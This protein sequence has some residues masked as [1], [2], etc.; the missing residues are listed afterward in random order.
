MANRDHALYYKR[1]ARDWHEAMPLGNGSMGAMVFGGSQ[2]ETLQLNEDTL[3]SGRPSDEGGYQIK[4][5][6]GEVR[7]LLRQKKYSAADALTDE[8]TGVHDSES[9]QMAGD[10]H[11]NFGK[12]EVKDFERWLD[13]STG[14]CSVGYK[15]DGVST[16][17]ECFISHPHQVLAM[18]MTADKPGVVDFDLS[19]SSPLSGKGS[20]EGDVY[21]FKGQCPY[22]NHSRRPNGEEKITWEQDGQGGIKYVVKIKVIPVGGKMTTGEK[23]ELRVSASDEA[24][25]LMTI[26]TGFRGWDQEPCDDDE[27]LERECDELISKAEGDGWGKI[28]SAHEADFK[29]LYE[30]M[31]LDLKGEDL[32]TTDERLSDS[33][34]ADH[35]RALVNLVFNFGRYLLVSSSRVGSQPTNLQGIWNDKLVA[36]WRSNYTVNINTEMNYWPAETCHL[37]ELTEPL[38]RMIKEL[39]ISGRRPAKKLYDARGWCTHHNVDLWRYPYTGGSRAQHAFWPVCSTWLCQHVWEHYAFSGNQEVLKEFLP[40]MKSAAEFLLD[41]MVTNERGELTTSPSTSPENRFID[42][43]TGE[44]SSICEG[45]AMDLTMIRELFENI[46]EASEI[47]GERDELVKQ[48][49]VALEKLAMPSIGQDGR[50]LEFGIEAEEPQPEHRHI[51]HLYGVHPGWM[52]TPNHLSE[53]YEACRKSLDFRGDESTGWAMGWR[54]A[55]WARFRDGDRAMKVLG[56]LLRF[57]DVTADDNGVKGGGLYANLFDAHPPF[58]IDGNFGVT[59]GITEMFVQSHEKASRLPSGLDIRCGLTGKEIPEGRLSERGDSGI[60]PYV[61]DLL[62]ALPTGLSEGSLN[63]LRAR[64]GFVIDLEWKSGKATKV[65]LHSKAGNPCLL[66]NEDELTYYALEAGHSQEVIF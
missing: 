42:P 22:N 25:L 57:I 58:Q 48:V 6:I 13:F 65:V 11:L 31:S 15:K 52:F 4:E 46:L 55:M 60:Q 10:L 2:E 37:P 26:R 45:S 44:P 19:M 21:V 9:Y 54:V 7:D 27:L 49:E 5:K 50:L 51:S 24:I 35:K 29:G 18:R 36:P 8:M 12:G 66:K 59:A 61:V 53:Y 34:D 14:V 30:R 17:R 20:A 32:R 23:G 56:N 1:P 62:P 3:W 63:G 41:F 64:G 28:R 38:L 40:I 43:E 39:S 33:Q 16:K 47:L